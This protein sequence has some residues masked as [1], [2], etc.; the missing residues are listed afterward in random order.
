MLFVKLISKNSR[1]HGLG[2]F[3]VGQIKRGTMLSFWGDEREVRFFEGKQHAKSLKNNS[4]ITR[5]TAV[6]LMGDW[7]VESIRLEEKDPTD[8]IN[9]SL[10][11][12]VGYL[13]GML[14]A[15]SDIKKGQELLLNY[16][17]LNAEY[18]I[19]VVRGFNPRR[20]LKACAE[21]VKKA[22]RSR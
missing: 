20:Q 13:A 9:H 15:L 10:K 17:L 1:V 12:N 19:N 3:A 11:P 5:E 6:R 2:C 4:R 21:Q 16:Q 22:F 8:Y 18:E 14:F 7:F